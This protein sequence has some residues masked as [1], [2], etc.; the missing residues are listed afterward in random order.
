MPLV[1][2]ITPTF[3]RARLLPRA[4]RAVLSQAF[5]DFEL[6]IID[7]GSTDET[8]QVVA[9]IN[10]PRIRYIAF[11]YNRGIG[12]ARNEGVRL[13]QGELIAFADS[14]DVWLP[15]KLDYQVELFLRYPQVELLFGDYLNINHLTGGVEKG[16]TQT[17]SAFRLLSVN[18]LEAEV[19]AVQSGIPEA[20]LRA[21]FFATPTVMVRAAAL[22]KVGN[23]DTALSG[24]EDF[25]FWWRAAINGVKFAYTTR[26]L[27]E[28]HKDQESITAK[29][30]AF[31]P[32]YLQALDICEQTARD[33]GRNDLLP[34]L[35]QAR[36]RVWRGLV[37]DHALLG[38][39]KQAL[40][41]FGASQR[42][43]SS[44]ASW[45]YLGAA[46]VGPRAITLAKRAR[47]VL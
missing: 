36:H 4:I 44:S 37:H 17:A 30:L 35:N 38:H 21:N 12:A 33:A 31:A 2:V 22:A 8:R 7:D 39:R 25:E 13:A 5:K 43:G 29:S 23:F 20:L 15:G 42:Y 9:Q 14:D 19:C 34:H 32:R 28:R 6:I 45:L 26:C 47:R 46:L 40:N 10:D 24:P 1:S 3:N 41:A 11:D 27:I 18:Y 16:F